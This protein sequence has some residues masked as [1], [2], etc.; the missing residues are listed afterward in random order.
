MIQTAMVAQQPLQRR[1]VL[2]SLAT[3]HC[4]TSSVSLADPHL[5][6][7]SAVNFADALGGFHAR[8]SEVTSVLT[9]HAPL[10]PHSIGLACGGRLVGLLFE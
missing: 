9:K 4:Q 8:D 2:R 1:H 6:F 3:T 10:G 5:H 7:A